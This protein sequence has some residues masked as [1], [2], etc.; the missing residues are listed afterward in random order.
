MSWHLFPITIHLISPSHFPQVDAIWHSQQIEGPPCRHSLDDVSETPSLVKERLQQRQG[1]RAQCVPK[2]GNI[3]QL[4][5]VHVNPQKLRAGSRLVRNPETLSQKLEV[6]VCAPPP[7]PY[8]TL[9]E[10]SAAKRF[11][12]LPRHAARSKMLR[13]LRTNPKQLQPFGILKP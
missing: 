8:R 3:S 2:P 1:A 4:L 6:L 12:C 7:W 13:T 11:G 10:P 5:G 9:M